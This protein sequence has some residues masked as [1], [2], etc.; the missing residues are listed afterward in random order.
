MKVK[1]SRKVKT[2]EET[3]CT[4]CGAV[5]S[6][7]SLGEEGWHKVTTVC[8]INLSNKIKEQGKRIAELE[9]EVGIIGRDLTNAQDNE[10]K[11][12]Q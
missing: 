12:T 6:E 4:I 1:H 8:L 5:A 11:G 10:R 7:S 3:T 2:M 9:R